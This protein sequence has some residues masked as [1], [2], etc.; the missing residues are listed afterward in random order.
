MKSVKEVKIIA[1][2]GRERAFGNFLVSQVSRGPKLVPSVS[3]Q[4]VSTCGCA[5][6]RP[7][8]GSQVQ[9]PLG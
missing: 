9:W 8:R 1:R 7:S 6:C 3:C 2:L 5:A 4:G